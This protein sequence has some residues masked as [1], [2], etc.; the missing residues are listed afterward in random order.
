MSSAVTVRCEAEG[1]KVLSTSLQP[2][3]NDAVTE[4]LP[5]VRFIAARIAA[6]IPASVEL[7]DLVQT[8]TLGLIDAVRRYDPSKGIPFTAYARYR[9]RGAILDAL[10][11][12][13]WAT[14]NQRAQ[15]KAIAS[16][17]TADGSSDARPIPVLQS[18]S[19]GLSFFEPPGIGRRSSRNGRSLW[20][21]PPSRP[22]LRSKRS[23]GTSE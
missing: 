9:I 19:G 21:K 4:N 18:R 2:A 17:A 14:R 13:D 16:A 7:D 12:A 8:G 1:I 5:L 20:R 3:E 23:E 6:T 10:R 15:R 22:A 11:S